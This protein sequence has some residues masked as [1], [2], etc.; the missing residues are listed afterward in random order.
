MRSDAQPGKIALVEANPEKY[1]ERGEMEQP[2][3]SGL[4]TWSPPVIVD[5]KMYLRDMDVL[6]CYD[7]KGALT[8]RA[9]R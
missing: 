1:V 3:G 9:D 8:A 5:G 6:L 4:N 7:I 2:D